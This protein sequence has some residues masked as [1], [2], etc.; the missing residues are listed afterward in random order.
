VSATALLGGDI[1]IADTSVWR[2]THR[3]PDDLK[4]AWESALRRDRIATTPVI[5]FELFYRARENR[6]LYEEWRGALDA[7]RYYLLPDHSI[8]SLAREAYV[9]LIAGGQL[10]GMDLPDVLNAATAMQTGYPV[11]HVDKDY[12]RLSRLR[13]LSFVE[14][15]LPV[16]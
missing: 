16:P 3:F 1:Q 12:A 9:E 11:L 2:R 10:G 8:W 5:V 15:R 4:V 7:I 14:R 13:C 6:V